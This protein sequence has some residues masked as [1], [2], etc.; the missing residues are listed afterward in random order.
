M[1]DAITKILK[2]MMTAFGLIVIAVTVAA[3]HPSASPPAPEWESHFWNPRQSADDFVL[4]MPCGGG[5]AFR[6]IATTLPGNWLT[7]RSV[8][9]GSPDTGSGYA[10]YHHRSHIAGSLS[11]TGDP[12]ARHYWI[13]KYEVTKDQY[14]AV[15]S[16]ACPAPSIQGRIPVSNLS[17]F[18]AVDFTRAYTE[19][20]MQ[21][22]ADKLPQEDGDP[23]FIRL[24]TEAEWEYAARGGEK[25]S[26]R[27][28]LE[29]RFPMPDGNLNRYAA[30]QGGDSCNG[31]LQLIGSRDPNPLGIHDILGN[32]EEMMLEPFRMIRAGRTHGQIGGMVTRGGSC[33]TSAADLSAATR[34]ESSYFNK[35]TGKPVTRQMTGF[36]VVITAQVQVSHGRITALR[37]G[38]SAL[39][40][41][42]APAASAEAPRD[43]ASRLEALANRSD[44]DEAGRIIRDVATLIRQDASTRADIERRSIQAAIRSGAVIIRQYRDELSRLENVETVV[45][46]RREA[47][48][49]D[50]AEQLREAERT[51]DFLKR[52]IN[53]TES[54]YTNV[55]SQTA[56][57]YPIT[58]L[59]D[60]AMIVRRHFLDVGATPIADFAMLFTK[61]VKRWSTT[62]GGDIT[63][64]LRELN[65]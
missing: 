43:P 36:R 45:A 21:N 2:R 32:V 41:G 13:G 49:N 28:F 20:L 63:A 65:E 34:T 53:V 35:R 12:G 64:F 51:R 31:K 11:G 24:P 3:A 8:R 17:W 15:A 52:R 56:E 61:Q 6:R 5:M 9:L 62:G 44:D 26:D 33:T 60:Q 22:A 30:F 40:G 42:S 23:A 46:I 7:D 1:S 27:D 54:V 18:N 29:P 55:L 10:H 38:W 58:L 59:D 37:D 25:V 14:D 4:P 57:D 16:E 39:S 47:V 48:G 19:W 50:A